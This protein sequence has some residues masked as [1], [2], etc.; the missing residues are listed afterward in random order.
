LTVRR[1]FWLWI[2]FAVALL[3]AGLLAR[4]GFESVSVLGATEQEADEG[5]FSLGQNSMVVAKQG[6]DL[7][8]WLT[9]HVGQ[10]VRLRLESEKGQ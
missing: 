3:G 7:H 6:S 4:D 8:K 1:V 2:V 5:Y 9:S 10:R